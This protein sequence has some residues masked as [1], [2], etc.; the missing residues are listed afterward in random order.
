[1][2]L[3]EPALA[4]RFCDR[5]L[6]VHGDGLTESGPARTML[7]AERLSALYDYPMLAVECGGQMSYN[8]V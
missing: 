4:W 7:T 5:V 1:M 2:V 3:R 8:F 6:L